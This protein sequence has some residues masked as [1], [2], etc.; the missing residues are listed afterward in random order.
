MSIQL[1]DVGVK[2]EGVWLPKGEQHMLDWMTIGKRAARI[3]PE[4]KITY[5][6]WK[7]EAAMRIFSEFRPRWTDSIF[8]DVGGHCGFWSM[9]WGQKMNGIVAYEPI[10]VLRQLYQE[11]VTGNG[12]DWNLVTL[13]PMALSD[14]PGELDMKYNPSNTGA[15]RMYADKDERRFEPIKVQVETLD[16][17]LPD[18]LQGR[19][20]GVLK[21]DCEGF[22]EKVIRGG[23]KMIREH[24]PLIVVE[25]KFERKHFDFEKDGAVRALQKMGYSVEKEISGDHIMVP[26]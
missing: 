6:W 21:I 5:Q 26:R 20:M 9:W 12:V 1:E 2:V 19:K 18:A 7:Q 24:K 17:T 25:Q 13:L 23:S 10:H 16:R 4:K 3:G 8:V 14:T 22:E 11:N 15:T